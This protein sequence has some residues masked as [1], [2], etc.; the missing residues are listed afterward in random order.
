MKILLL[1]DV[2]GR[3]GRKALNK[4]L[5]DFKKKEE[6]DVVIA[7]VENVAGGIGATPKTLRYLQNCG[8]DI[9][10]G[11]NHIWD[12][13][14]DVVEKFNVVRP[15]N[16]PENFKGKGLINFEEFNL[17]VIS[18]CGNLFM[19]P[20]R[21]PFKVINNLLKEA[22]FK[23]II[24]DFHAEATAEKQAF[25]HY[26]KGK[27]SVLVGTHTHVQTADEDIIEGTAYITDLGFCG[28]KNSV[29]GMK[30]SS[31]LRKFMNL[32][33]ARL[34]A[35]KEFPAIINGLLVELKEGK[36]VWLKR[37]SQVIME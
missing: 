7:N 18:L 37:I 27:V 25:L 34:Q 15:A 12:R 20:I 14:E 31:A 3:V 13:D 33:P 29:I 32:I 8:V 11:G 21:S 17:S 28:P 22:K 2:F 19:A 23:N 10:T 36:A 6:I 5:P 24:I 35:Q 16:Y 30:I 4:W 9:F 26:V 1:G